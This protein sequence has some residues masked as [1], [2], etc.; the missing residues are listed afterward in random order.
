MEVSRASRIMLWLVATSILSGELHFRCSAGFKY[1][2]VTAT[3]ATMT[4]VHLLYSYLDPDLDSES[5][6]PGRKQEW[7]L[8]QISLW[9][10]TST[11]LFWLMDHHVMYVTAA[12]A[13]LRERDL[14]ILIPQAT[15]GAVGSS[16]A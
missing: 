8:S 15:L 3:S 7:S 16:G 4:T 14:G 1:H 10:A 11:P 2:D 6:R 12:T 9:L 13:G 5:A